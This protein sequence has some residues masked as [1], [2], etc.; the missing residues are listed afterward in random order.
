MVKRNVRSGGGFTLVEM[1]VVILLIAVLVAILLPAL[2]RA[3]EAARQVTCQS[4][5]RQ[6]GIAFT[7]YATQ[8]GG[9]M[10]PCGFPYTNPATGV[11]TGPNTFVYLNQFMASATVA[12]DSGT[13]GA[14]SEAFRCPSDNMN[15]LAQAGTSY[16]FNFVGTWTDV[17]H[18]RHYM[19]RQCTGQMNA[20]W[21]PLSTL[22]QDGPGGGWMMQR[23]QGKMYSASPADTYL[24]MEYWGASLN[25]SDDYCE[26]RNPQR[27]VKQALML[28][29]DY[30]V[31]PPNPYY[32][33]CPYTADVDSYA[34]NAQ[35][36]LEMRTSRQQWGRNFADVTGFKAS[37]HRG[38][39]NILT[40]DGHSEPID[41]KST[42]GRP[43]ATTTTVVGNPQWTAIPD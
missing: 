28:D 21:S 15:Y 19:Q 25:P 26:I 30:A 40:M 24:M 36:K 34:E 4:N 18:P 13:L 38:T 23:G 42:L 3:R 31:T 20:D 7:N 10:P 6:F 9:F 22:D 39:S 1:L 43:V 17:N 41:L 35:A 11:T 16:C 5:L 2:A 27:A 37:F 32:F 33:T 29:G 14:E 12:I 8:N